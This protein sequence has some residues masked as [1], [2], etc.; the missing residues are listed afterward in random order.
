MV[1]VLDG[2][3]ESRV[4]FQNITRAGLFCFSYNSDNTIMLTPL[5]HQPNYLVPFFFED[6]TLKGRQWEPLS[7]YG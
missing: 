4:R 6:D 5:K 1:S 7:N 2:V 3:R